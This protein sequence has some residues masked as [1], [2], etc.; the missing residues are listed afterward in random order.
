MLFNKNNNGA[1]ELRAITGN[2]FANNTF[3]KVKSEIDFAID[4]VAKVVSHA[5]TNKAQTD[6]AAG[7][8]NELIR[9]VQAPVAFLATLK[10][11]QKNDVSHEDSG[12]KVK[13]AAEGEK[14]PWQWQLDK[15]DQLHLETYY[16]NVDRLIDYLERTNNTEWFASPQRTKLNSQLMKSAAMFNEY[17]PIDNSS[18]LF[19][20]LAPFVREA[21]RIYMKPALGAD[22][23]ILRAATDLN[24]T[25]KTLLEYALAPIPLYALSLAMR[26][27][28]FSIIPQGVIRKAISSTQTMN[29]G[30]VPTIKDLEIAS[31]WL[32][33][34]AETLLDLMKRIRRADVQP[35]T[36]IPVNKATN[37]FFRV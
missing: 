7:T 29:A 16:Q 24:P 1:A 4:D 35:T 3:E 13:I 30:E 27:T 36:F 12:R 20:L 22:Y 25:Q 17:Y 15:D 6:Y 37:K 18:R 23:E 5:V 10:L 28:A 11:Y 19:M 14:M 32:E 34:D 8:V 21:E 31:D 26:R 2:Y 33:D 9:Y